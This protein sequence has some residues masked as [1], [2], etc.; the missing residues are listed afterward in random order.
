MM[1]TSL[2]CCRPDELHA[3]VECFAGPSM[4]YPTGKLLP[5]SVGDVSARQ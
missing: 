5:L 3:F 1:V 2:G 4:S